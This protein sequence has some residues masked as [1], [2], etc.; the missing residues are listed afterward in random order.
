[1]E[2]AYFL[3][4]IFGHRVDRVTQQGLSRFLRPQVE[5]E[6]VCYEG[7]IDS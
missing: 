6:V 2:L 4:D 1:M 3:E 7:G 5:E